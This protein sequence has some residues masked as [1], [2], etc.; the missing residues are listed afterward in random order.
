MTLKD[1]ISTRYGVGTHRQVSRLSKLQTKLASSKNHVIFLERCLFFLLIPTFLQFCC[2]VKSNRAQRITKRCKHQL[3]KETLHLERKKWHRTS[4]QIRQIKNTLQR[5]SNADY[6]IISRV[7][8]S[9]YEKAFQKN[10]TRLVKKF[11]NLKEKQKPDPK[12]PT[13][14]S[15]IKNPFLNLQKDNPL[16][17]EVESQEA[18]DLRHETAGILKKA[19][20]PKSN[21]T[22]QQKKG[23][24]YLK[25]NKDIAVT[26]YDKGQG[27]V[28]IDREELVKKTESEFKNTKLDTPNTTDSFERKIQTTL[29]DL[30][31]EGKFDDKTYK[32]IYPSGSITPA[33]TPAVKAHKQSKGYPVRL[34]TSHITAPPKNTW[35]PILTRSLNLL[36]KA[37]LTTL[38][39]LLNF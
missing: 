37:A 39:T 36:L 20:N 13:R 2:P 22:S 8:N 21:L 34:I 4:H 7:T 6:D 38:K 32:D 15:L 10:K 29:R 11:E 5:L 19:K 27:F 31:K 35:P 28:V 30:K 14:P 16:P 1:H 12:P 3:L 17:P 23:L 9:V 25:K 26:E 18:Q 24:S 33:A